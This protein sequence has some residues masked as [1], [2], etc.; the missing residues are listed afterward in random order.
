MKANFFLISLL[1][2]SV[3][4]LSCGVENI[5]HCYECGEGSE[6]NSCKTCDNK[7]F[8][9]LDNVLCLPCDHEIYGQIWCNGICSNTIHYDLKQSEFNCLGVCKVGYFKLNNKCVPCSYYI[10]NCINCGYDT[11]GF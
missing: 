11:Y 5:A 9:F 1:I 8:P 4:I 6:I 2:F 10:S 3:N 7:Y